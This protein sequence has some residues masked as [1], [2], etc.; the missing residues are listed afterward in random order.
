MAGPALLYGTR[1]LGP[2]V[3]PV[4]SA[5]SP[6]CAGALQPGLALRAGAPAALAGAF[7]GA[8]TDGLLAGYQSR[9]RNSGPPGGVLLR[10]IDQAPR[11]AALAGGAGPRGTRRAGLGHLGQLRR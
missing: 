2:P 9:F 7:R 8:I 5:Q 1:R 6:L 10:R 4:R 3:G 11:P